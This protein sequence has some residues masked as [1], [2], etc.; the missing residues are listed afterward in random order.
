MYFI[1]LYVLIQNFTLLFSVFA[2]S[3]CFYCSSNVLIFVVVVLFMC[4][5]INSL[6][7]CCYWP[8]LFFLGSCCQFKCYCCFFH[9]SCLCTTL[10][11]TIN[12]IN[13]WLQRIVYRYIIIS[14]VLC[15][16]H[17]LLHIS[18]FLSSFGKFS[19]Y[20]YCF[21]KFH[22]YFQ[23]FNFSFKKKQKIS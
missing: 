12:M 6:F 23:F 20:K 1:L 2:N 21:V 17:W 8:R 22:S 3:R 10:L 5:H 9:Y 11:Y 19:V 15:F 7:C 13:V 16:F 4:F 18:L 14:S